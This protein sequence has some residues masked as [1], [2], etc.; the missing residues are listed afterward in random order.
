MKTPTFCEACPDQGSEFCAL[1]DSAVTIASKAKLVGGY[2]LVPVRFLGQWDE[3]AGHLPVLREPFANAKED[4]AACVRAHQPDVIPLTD[5]PH[6]Y[7][8]RRGAPSISQELQ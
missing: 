5:W 3:P 7:G 2:A 8:S 1:N 6:L 4:V